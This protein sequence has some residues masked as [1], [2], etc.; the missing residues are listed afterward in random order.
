MK[1]PFKRITVLL[2]A[3]CMLVG[4]VAC[5]ATT[6]NQ[7]ELSPPADQPPDVEVSENVGNS[8]EDQPI[9]PTLPPEP[10]DE[11]P[12]PSDTPEQSSKD[13]AEQPPA[14]SD[15]PDV[16]RPQFSLSEIPAY[17]GKAFVV[18]N[19]H[20]PFFTA[21]EITNESFEHYAP[22]DSLG[23]CGVATACVGLDIMPTEE[24]GSIGMV[25]PSGWHTIRY[26]GV[27]DGNYLYNRCHLIGYQLTGE[28][29]NTSNL[30]TGTRYLN[31]EGMLPYENLIA[32]YVEDSGNHVLYR[33]TP[34]FEGDNLLATGV[35][36][37]G[38]SVEDNGQDVR[39]CVFAYNVQPGIVIDY[40]TGESQLADG[41]SVDPPEEDTPVI[42]VPDKPDET[43]DPDVGAAPN[44]IL[45]TNT[46]KF[47]YPSCSSVDDMKEKNKQEYSGSRDDLINQGYSPCG[48][49]HP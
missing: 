4:I 7:S 33:V 24:R 23:R 22:L 6:P 47:H 41:Y 2:L 9:A 5:G 20:Q 49:C 29:A 16:G 30:I 32:E 26:N 17:S 37:E 19:D 21:D 48:R 46:K 1:L 45:N 12:L 15:K 31:I 44:Y 14:N 10:S 34:I 11:Q 8:G 43:P 13:P 40:A 28:N 35:L 27:V 38:M 25:K 39:F 36:M 18:I 42:P 3:L